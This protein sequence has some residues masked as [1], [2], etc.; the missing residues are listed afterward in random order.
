MLLRR[1]P[2]EPG[3]SAENNDYSHLVI[4]GGLDVPSD[5]FVSMEM[6]RRGLIRHFHVSTNPAFDNNSEIWGRVDNP[7]KQ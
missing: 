1:G 4:W 3:A 2:R 7:I 5:G 6:Q